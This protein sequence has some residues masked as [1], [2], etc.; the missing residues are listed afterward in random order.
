MKFE[1]MLLM[2]V[3]VLGMGC[4]GAEES[5]NEDSRAPAS[6]LASVWTDDDLGEP[7]GAG[8]VRADAAVD[9]EVVVTG[10]V[11]DFVDGFAV[12]KLIDPK[13]KSCRERSGDNCPTPWDYCCDTPEDRRDNTITVEVHDEGRPLRSSLKGV[14]G[15]DYLDMLVVKGKVARDDAGNVTVVAGAIKKL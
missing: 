14:N 9:S 11:R 10:R 3:L 4:G 6:P 13:L 2:L 1:W 7:Q 5:S 8:A 15:L 12:I